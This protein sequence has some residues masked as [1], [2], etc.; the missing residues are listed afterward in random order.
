MAV[1]QLLKWVGN[2]KKFASE[3]ISFF[4]QDFGDYY[5]PFLG[6]G[7]VLAELLYSKNKLLRHNFKHTYGSD[8]LPFLIGIF[9]YV[10]NDPETIADYYENCIQSFMDDPK[11]EYENI[12]ERFN[13]NHNPLDFCVLTR[14]CY[15]GIIRFRKSDGY[16][17]TP[18]GPHKPITGDSFRKR[19][20]LWNSLIRDTTFRVE[21]F[22]TAMDRAKPGDLIYCDPPYT[23]SQSILY[24]S[25]NFSVLDLW[26]KIEE[27]KNRGVYVALSINGSRKSNT[28]DIS[29]IPPEGLFKTRVLIDCGISMVDRLQNAGKSMDNDRVMDQLLLTWELPTEEIS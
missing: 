29:V 5:E 14:T 2:K 21:S 10:K 16:M 18:I 8:V 27:C 19:V 25:Q 9:N 28:K 26:K 23:H 7:A 1:T 20:K 15:S 17:S 24:G 11:Q 12:K 3:I 13:I 22:Q 4:P 6:S